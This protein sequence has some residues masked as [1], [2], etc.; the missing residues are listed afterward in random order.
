VEIVATKSARRS[1]PAAVEI[2][3]VEHE[4]GVVVCAIYE[5]INRCG[6]DNHSQI[7]TKDNDTRVDFE[8]R[9]PRGVNLKAQS[10]TGD[11]TATGLGGSVSAG[12]VSGDV[13]I[14]TTG[15]AR[16]SSVSGSVDVRMGRAD[17][18]DRLAFST[19]SGNI[20]LEIAGD[21]NTDVSFTTVSGS[22]D[23]DWPITTSTTRGRGLR[24]TIGNGGRRLTFSTVSGNVDIRRAN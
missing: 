22:F 24:G 20:T 2:K 6:P 11:V 3:V 14:A 18:T 19:V 23:S 12:S 1:D 16:A 15:V 4:D 17:W 9:L 8:V 13:R 21:L 5:S 7:S 10:V